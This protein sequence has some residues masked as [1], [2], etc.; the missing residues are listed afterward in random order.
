MSDES[1]H[2][3]DRDDNQNHDRDDEDLEPQGRPPLI[4]PQEPSAS[5]A[6]AAPGGLPLD[7]RRSEAGEQGINSSGDTVADDDRGE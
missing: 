7:D 5:V 2:N 6:G 1:R 3:D 4:A